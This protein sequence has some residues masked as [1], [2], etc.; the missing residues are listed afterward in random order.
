MQLRYQLFHSKLNAK[1]GIYCNFIDIY[2]VYRPVLYKP[3]LDVS[4]QLCMF[5]SAQRGLKLLRTLGAK[6][7]YFR[8]AA[9]IRQLLLVLF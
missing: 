7:F 3:Q 9:T 1:V 5:S 2:K 4:L 8:S 6:M